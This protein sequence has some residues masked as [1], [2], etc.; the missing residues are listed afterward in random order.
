M[1]RICF[2]TH[3]IAPTT[4]GGCGV[5]LYNAAC[6]LLRKGHEVIFVLD[7]PHDYFDRFQG[8]DRLRFPN[9]EKCRAYHVESIVARSD[10]NENSFPFPSLWKAYRIHLACKYVAER[11][12][13]DLIEFHDFLG[14]GHYALTAKAVGLCYQATHLAVRLHSSI[15]VMDIHS[16]SARLHAHNHF[17]HDLERSALQLAEAIL[18][19]SPSYLR[20]AY[21]PFY[22]LWFGR[23]V[24][25]QSPL[26][27]VP[28]KNNYSDEDHVILF[29]GRIFSMK[30]V[31]VFVDAAVEMLRRC[32]E[33]RFV[34]AGYDSREAPDGS[35]TYEQFLRSKI[36]SRFQSAFEFVGQLDRLQVESLLPRVRF[37]VFPN[38]YESFCY[39]AHEL[40]AAGI[41]VIV[42]NIPGFRDFFRHE[43]N[44]LVFDGTV[45]DLARQ[46]MRL[47]ND[48]ALR[49][50]LI[51]PYPVATRPLGDIYDNPPR[52]SW[53]VRGDHASCSL[54]VCVIGEEGALFQE[55][56]GSLE[57]VHKSDMRIVHL[58]PAGSTK[59]EARGWVLGQLFQFRSL[60]GDALLPT[61]VRT[62]QALLLLRAGDRVAPDF[63]R[64]ACNTLARQ[65]QIG[66]VG[67]W[68]RVRAA[69]KE[70]IENFPFDASPELLPFLSG[71]M[72]HRF[73]VRTLPDRMLIDVFD[74]KAG[75]CGEI[76]YVWSLDAQGQRGLIIP[77]PLVERGEE[78]HAV[79]SLNELSALILRDTS[80]WH[81]SRLARL[82]V[83]YVGYARAHRFPHPSLHEAP[84]VEPRL[85]RLVRRVYTMPGYA[86]ARNAAFAFYRL[87][88]SLDR[89]YGKTNAL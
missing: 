21:Q 78:P 5:L 60:E 10:L 18:Y 76:A 88:R 46:M 38:H 29:Y 9:P 66:F 23:V 24:E 53:I 39:A 22:P 77:E 62:C 41:P 28:S 7:L 50:R 79:P 69:E 82:L 71:K 65:P 45:E 59:N 19:P 26:V 11:E 43:E 42:S 4:W 64:V 49:Q 30:G 17:V 85:W 81:Q 89:G 57:R 52:D 87:W 56:I 72:L 15:E 58:R 83:W 14:V 47:W 31:D 80:Y 33:V 13:P 67:A 34:L 55:T 3:E 63:I 36:P 2:V 16:S 86:V 54:L 25:S 27:D 75:A 12:Q 48:H 74:S 40:Y 61:E 51:F 8:V 44:A 37:A 68:H 32:S 84:V 20:E 35:L 73:V 70:C 6:M 1:K